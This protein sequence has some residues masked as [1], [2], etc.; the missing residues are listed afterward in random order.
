MPRGRGSVEPGQPESFIDPE[1]KPPEQR[2]QEAEAAKVEAEARKTAYEAT[3]EGLSLG[4]LALSALVGIA[5]VAA[6]MIT[7]ELWLVPFGV[8]V[9]VAG[10]ARRGSH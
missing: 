5:V 8:S 10:L 2:R 3:R 6:G 7:A 4:I 1:V 9:L